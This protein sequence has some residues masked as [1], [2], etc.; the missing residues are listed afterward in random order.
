MRRGCWG[1]TGGAATLSYLLALVH[2][3][4]TLI[5]DGLPVSVR[6]IVPAPLHG[7][8][9]AAVGVLLALVGWLSFDGDAGVFYL[10]MAVSVLAVFSFTAY[11]GAST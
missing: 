11:R 10:V 6:G 5:T 9:E 4:M 2:L 7:L 1:L 3:V 8:V